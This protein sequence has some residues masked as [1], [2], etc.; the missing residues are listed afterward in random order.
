VYGIQEAGGARAAGVDHA[1]DAGHTVRAAQAGG[2]NPASAVDGAALPPVEVL[3]TASEA[4]AA[5]WMAH[6]LRWAH[7]SGRIAWEDMAVLTRTAGQVT[8]VRAALAAAGVPVHVPGSEVLSTDQ[9]A[10]A[11]L[12]A[13][14]EHCVAPGGLDGPGALALAASSLGGMDAVEIRALRRALKAAAGG[15]PGGPDGQPGLAAGAK[16]DA[17]HPGGRAGAGDPTVVAGAPPEAIGEAGPADSAARLAAALA[18]GQGLDQVPGPVGQKA[19]RLAQVLAAGREAAAEASSTA[20][21]VL[22]ALWEQSGLADRWQGEALRGDSSLRSRP[23]DLSHLLAGGWR[24]E[25]A[26]ADLDAVCALFAAAARFDARRA[27]AGARGFAD[28]LAAQQVPSDTV[29]PHAP[30]DDR[31]TVCTA[32][33]AAGREWDVVGLIGLQE[34]VWPNLKLRDTLMGAGELADLVDARADLGGAVTG[35]AE[36]R[37]A[38]LDDETRMCALAVSRAKRHLVVVTVTNDD[39]RPSQ[40]ADLIDPDG[41]ALAG[42]HERPKTGLP[43]PYDL[44]GLV[45]QARYALVQG[46]AEPQP[47]LVRPDP[48]PAGAATAASA[49]RVLAVLAAIGTPGAHPDQWAGLLPPSTDQPLHGEGEAIWLSPSKVESLEDCPLR[50]LLDSAGGHGEASLK[51]DR[52]SLIHALAQEFPHAGPDELRGHLAQRWAELG[53]PDTYSN[54]LAYQEALDMASRLGVYLQAH[55]QVLAVEQAV[56]Y[57]ANGVV[58]AGIIDR[59]EPVDQVDGQ[60]AARVVDFK[61]GAVV[62]SVAQAK[63]NPQLGVYQAAVESGAVPGVA[64]AAGATLVYLSQGKEAYQRH[65]PAPDQA[66]DPAWVDKLLE[67]CRHRV[68]QARFQA[69]PGP[70]CRFCQVAACCPAQSVGQAVTA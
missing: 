55:P 13:A 58:V 56:R 50:W 47:G 10:V 69:N 32:T 22:W 29:A 16:A 48:T 40:F 66:A 9:P 30:Q 1:P 26:D 57:E 20:Y 33:A 15:P 60:P 63:V 18:T 24:G 27:G 67:R 38:V 34:E 35:F 52:G 3:V 44:R 11:A 41:A 64:K 49:A 17:G 46:G 39:T 8:V 45:A 42:A 61:T 51:A 28:Y 54:R 5:A 14:L 4:E 21:R 43:A 2:V 25:W 7:L 62:P 59:L 12:V 70:G 68:S 37:R 23:G 6:Q 53:L 36:R 31:V 19:R 65:Q